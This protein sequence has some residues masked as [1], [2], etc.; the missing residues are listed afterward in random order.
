MH[1]NFLAR[2][3]AREPVSGDVKRL[4]LL[5]NNL[6]TYGDCIANPSFQWL[7]SWKSP[8][9]PI[10]AGDLDYVGEVEH[11]QIAKRFLKRYPNI[12]EQNYN[13]LLFQVQSTQV[14]R[15]SRSANAFMY[16]IFEGRGSLGTCK[17]VPFSV[18]SNSPNE[19]F[20]LRFFDN[21]PAYTNEVLDNNSTYYDSINY[22]NYH[23][24]YLIHDIKEKLQFKDSCEWNIEVTDVLSLF[25]ACAFDV[26]V[27][28]NTD[29][30]C[31]L[32]D[33]KDT[34]IIEY[35][36]DL[37]DYYEKG[38]GI[39]LSYSISSPLLQDFVNSIDNVLLG[40]SPQIAKLRFA[41]AETVLPYLAL[42]GLYKDSFELH[43][44]TPE[45]NINE[46]LWRTSNLS[47]FAANVAWVLYNCT[48]SHSS[49]FYRVKL[50]HNEME[51]MFP[52]CNEI[53]C[54]YETLKQL[55][56]AQLSNDFDAMCGTIPPVLAENVLF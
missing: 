9:T 19:D 29:M 10:L 33:F 25:T 3:G 48:S 51:Q 4:L 1:F 7:K 2:H 39:D 34:S 13:P 37:E 50:L 42:L 5:Q 53:Y 6:N 41:H 11:Y 40:I 8:Y 12:F 21:C 22:L 44:N 35:Y 38:Y 14:P 16:S 55:Y 17:Y 32:F 24:K 15:T 45:S 18:F 49:P 47:P 26:S 31:Q 27:Q 28:N 54:P 46:R 56:Q 20:T 30:F 43:W 52:G 36:M 23:S